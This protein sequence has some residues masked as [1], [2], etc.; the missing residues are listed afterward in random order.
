[1]TDAPISGSPFASVTMP[2]I[3]EENPLPML[4][5]DLFVI[6]PQAISIWTSETALGSSL[7]GFQ[8]SFLT[9]SRLLS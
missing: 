4:P 8:I 9:A 2:F 7:T 1:M 6:Y 5:K 3:P